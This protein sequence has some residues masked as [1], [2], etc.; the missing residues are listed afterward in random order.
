MNMTLIKGSELQGSSGSCIIE[1]PG[2][3]LSLTFVKRW[4]KRRVLLHSWQCQPTDCHYFPVFLQA[5]HWLNMWRKKSK[6]AN[7]S[8][9]DL[10]NTNADREQHK[11][12][13]IL[14]LGI[15]GGHICFNSFPVWKPFLDG[16]PNVLASES[17]NNYF[18]HLKRM[19]LNSYAASTV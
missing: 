4:N 10:H 12:L 15:D 8:L 18:F 9:N 2:L 13:E 19:K 16:S 5:F 6:E 3:Q 1:G 17:P 7:V 11:N 14:H